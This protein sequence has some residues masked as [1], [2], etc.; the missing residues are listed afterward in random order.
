MIGESRPAMQQ[1]TFDLGLPPRFGEAD[2]LVSGSNEAAFQA[3]SGWPLWPD[4]VLV[5]LGPEGCGKSH[6]AAIWAARAGARFIDPASL[7]EAALP[8]LLDRPGVIEDADRLTGREPDLFHLLNLVREA[9]SFL[10]VTARRPP[11]A[12][13]LAT[14]DL[15][16]R[17]RLA[18]AV[19]IGLPDEDLVRAVLVKL[20]ADRQ[21]SVDEG[22]VGYLAVRLDRS[23]DAAR[24]CVAAMD[25]AGLALNRKLTRPMAAQ[26]L[27]ELQ[28]D[29][30]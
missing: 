2:F 17:L 23:I 16:S 25:R 19:T 5:L 15:L 12:W 1:L 22:L 10:L 30:G 4:R 18:P 27:A 8:G 11:E 29:D 9:G 13:G 24:R 28:L 6:L 20:F 14:P 21:I 7:T 26:V 3:V